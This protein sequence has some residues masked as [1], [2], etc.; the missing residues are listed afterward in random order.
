M[1]GCLYDFP[2]FEKKQF[3]MAWSKI[4]FILEIFLKKELYLV[5]GFLYKNDVL[6]DFSVRKQELPP[7]CWSV[8]M[9]SDDSQ[10]TNKSGVGGGGSQKESSLLPIGHLGVMYD[11]QLHNYALFYSHPDRVNVLS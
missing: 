10:A 7:V 1:A 2:N 8:F 3:K 6:G 4:V 11:F 5:K 9:Y